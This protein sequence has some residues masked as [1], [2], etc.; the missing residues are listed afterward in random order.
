MGEHLQMDPMKLKFYSH[1]NTPEGP[2]AE[3]KRVPEMTLDN[4]LNP[5]TYGTR[6]SM[7][8]LLSHVR[9]LF[10]SIRHCLL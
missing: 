9:S 3:I 7:L 8:L 1:R 6:M 2:N 10:D 4:M 5:Y